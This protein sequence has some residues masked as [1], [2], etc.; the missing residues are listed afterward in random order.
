MAALHL[1]NRRRL[2]DAVEK[3]EKKTV[4]V[5]ERYNQNSKEKCQE[6]VGDCLLSTSFWHFPSI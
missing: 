1:A 2:E 5:Q 6:K 4:T 3:L